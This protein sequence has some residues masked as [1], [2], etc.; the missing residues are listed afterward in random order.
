MD[1]TAV[2][3][4]QIRATTTAAKSRWYCENPDCDGEPHDGWTWCTHTGDQEH[5]PACRH[6]RPDQR[7]P[8][9]DWLVW[10]FIAGRG[11]GKTRSAAEWVT[12][13][14]KR[15]G[16]RRGALVGRTPADVRDVMVEGESGLIAVGEAHGFRPTFQPTKRRLVWPNGAVAY[17][18]SAEVGDQLRGPQHDWAWVDE[19]AAW[20]EAAKG[21]QLG[22][23]WN[24]LMLG[25]RLG[26][27]P[28]VAFTTTPK[29]VALVRHVLDRA[30]TVA[31][32]KDSRDQLRAMWAIA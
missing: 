6:A 28:R 14:V 15:R 30:T 13:L 8:D 18:Y 2:L 16:Y 29:R 32:I 10:A 21:D 17:S 23:A 5:E 9:G 1:I 31:A 24:N 25:L 11:A 3:A 12:D 22:T 26:R 7:P 4:D 20:T 27:H 19:P